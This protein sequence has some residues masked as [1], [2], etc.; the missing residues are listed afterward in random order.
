MLFISLPQV[1][2]IGGADK[3]HAVCRECYG[4][5]VLGKENRDPQREETPPHLTVKQMERSA[6]RKL[7]SSLHL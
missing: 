3:Y 7:L 4:G 2:V 1:E 5:L 6:P